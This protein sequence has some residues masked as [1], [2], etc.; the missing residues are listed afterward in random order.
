MTNKIRLHSGLNVDPTRLTYR[1]IYIT[2]I[3]QGLSN[4]CRFAGQINQFYSVASHS[5]LVTSLLRAKH[6][7]T[8]TQ[9]YGL[10]H[11]ASEAYLV[12][13]PSPFKHK[14]PQYL[15]WEARA[16]R[17]VL[18]AFSLPPMTQEQARL[19]KQADIDALEIEKEV[20]FDGIGNLNIGNTRA[21]FLAKFAELYRYE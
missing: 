5:L 2:D 16:N 12:D 7:D 19:V 10:L 18:K 14:L 6:T 9:L 17:A 4:I 20:L 13:I 15:K 1:D 21:K 3:A 11:D 8:R